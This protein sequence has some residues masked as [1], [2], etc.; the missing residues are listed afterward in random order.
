MP[1]PAGTGWAEELIASILAAVTTSATDMLVESDALSADRC[2]GAYTQGDI[3][4][5]VDPPA[6]ESRPVNAPL[7]TR[8]DG[9]ADTIE[10]VPT[11]LRSRC[12]TRPDLYRRDGRTDN[13]PEQLAVSR[14]GSNGVPQQR[15]GFL[16]GCVEAECLSGSFVQFA[17][18]GVEVGFVCGDIGSLGQVLADQPV[19]VLV[20][21]T[22][23]R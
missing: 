5:A 3:D 2:S 19:R 4:A 9:D 22:L 15:F 23:P 13:A 21:W 10:A 18:D 12:K 8:I 20:G 6:V 1:D 16:A 17:G 7:E 14:R 11:W